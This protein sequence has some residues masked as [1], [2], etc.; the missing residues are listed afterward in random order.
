MGLCN[1][2]DSQDPVHRF[3]D[4]PPPE[5]RGADPSETLA[6]AVP[7]GA[8]EVRGDT[9]YLLQCKANG[10][11]VGIVEGQVGLG[12]GCGQE[13]LWRLRAGAY[14]SYQLLCAGHALG[15]VDGTVLVASRSPTGGDDGF[16]WKLMQGRGGW[17]QLRNL[18]NP[19]CNLQIGEGLGGVVYKEPAGKEWESF[20]LIDM[21]PYG[22]GI[23]DAHD[24]ARKC[25]EVVRQRDEQMEKN[26]VQAEMFR[27]ASNRLANTSQQMASHG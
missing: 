25:L 26:R 23:V 24:A 12:R 20:N 15:V 6:M 2:D 27:R 17:I 1:S 16:D 10:A 9:E 11:R 13:V 3:R 5:N 21:D 22:K 18:A 19:L 14:G 8:V 4:A 7:F